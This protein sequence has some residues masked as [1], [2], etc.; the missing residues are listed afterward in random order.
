MQINQIEIIKPDDWHVHLRDGQMLSAVARY[1]AQQFGRA[2]VMPNLPTPITT[3]ESA[4]AY[5][6]RI[7]N[8]VGV[9][10]SFVPLM[11]VYLTDTSSPD[12]IELGF[13]S[14]VWMAAKLYPAHATTHSAAGVRDIRNL[15][16]VFECMQR[17]DMPLLI[18]GEVTDPQV[19]VFDR[20]H[21]FIDRVLDPLLQRFPDLRVVFEHIT[22]RQAVDY[23]LSSN[24][25][26]AA[27][28]TPH[29]LVMNR[30]AMFEGGMRPHAYCLPV[31][32]REEHRLALRAAAISGN[33]KFFLGTDSAPH[34][35]ADKQSACGCA[36]IFNAPVAMQ[37]CAQVFDEEKALD[38]LEGFT[39]RHGAAFYRLAINTQ[40]LML[41][42]EVNRVEDRIDIEGVYVIPFFA[43]KEL[44]WWLNSDVSLG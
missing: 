6:Q 40:R 36:G 16:S 26:V 1:T 41:T 24:A 39:S 10:S 8:A 43:G 22:T 20:E 33:A 7:Q 11:T 21:V 13:E 12:E 35:M 34:A 31:A 28:I 17:I 5:R 27:T 42:R 30:N 25:C 4:L 23:V 19:D 18:H 38:K 3:I 14:N 44:N 9:D 37:V 29:H 32:K 15:D 2:L